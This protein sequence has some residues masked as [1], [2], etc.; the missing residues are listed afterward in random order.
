[1]LTVRSCCLL[2][3]ALVA[4]VAAAQPKPTIPPASE[5]QEDKLIATLRSDAPYQAKAEACRHLQVYG[6]KKAVPA[7]EQLLDDEKTSHMAR[8]ALE[9]IPDPA[10][11][12]A[13]RRALGRLK[14]RPLVGVI[15]SIGVRGD[16]Q[17]VDGLAKRLLDTDAMVA[18]AAARALGSIGTEQAASALEANLSRAPKGQ[19]LHMYEGLF[20]CA[21]ALVEAGQRTAAIRI[22]DSLRSIPEPHQVRGGAVRGAIL[23]RGRRGLRL[24]GEALAD[25]DYIVFSAA[26]HASQEMRGRRVTA[27][28]ASSLEKLD[29][30]RKVVLTE[31]LAMRQDETALPALFAQA[32]TGPVPARQAAIKGLVAV[33]SPEAVPELIK[34]LDDS[35]K[36]IAQ[37]AQESLAAMTVPEADQAVMTLLESSDPTKQLMSLDLI[38]RRRMTGAIDGLFAAA[39]SSKNEQ[40]RSNAVRRIGELGGPQQLPGMLGLLNGMSEAGDLRAAEQALRNLSTPN[41]K[42][43]DAAV[44]MVCDR[45]PEAKGPAKQVL[46]RVVGALGGSKALQ[47]IRTAM[48]DADPDARE[49]ATRAL[50]NWPGAEAAADMLALAETAATPSQRIAALRAYIGVIRDKNL[51]TGEQIA[52]AEK[53]HGLVERAAE[54]RLLLGVLGGIISPKALN[55]AGA[56]LDDSETSNEA[57]L[58]AVAIA[59]KLVE[60]RPEGIA[61]IMQKVVQTTGNA[62][63]KKRAQAVLDKAKK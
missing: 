29:T 43:D 1:M 54:K 50:L 14:G 47:T 24:L 35:D 12:E 36:A 25:E 49:E 15:G 34:L 13:F 27:V 48:R 46:L 51:R 37:T 11:E 45:I 31:S 10:V 23:A 22:Y 26:V 42:R 63:T 4:A 55:M 6:T 21:E 16:A 30:D 5:V 32:K 20:R 2:L 62:D 19:L 18:M 57:A 3:C 60:R 61:A 28:L 8:M 41:G 9:V 53:A 52:M 33:G 58:A 17:A 56:Y 59:E 7:L 44:A 40:V 39:R 38:G